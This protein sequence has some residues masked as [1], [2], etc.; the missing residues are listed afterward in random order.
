MHLDLIANNAIVIVDFPDS[1]A[2]AGCHDLRH[3]S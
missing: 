2:F 3:L 1:V